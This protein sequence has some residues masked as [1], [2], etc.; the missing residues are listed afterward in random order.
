MKVKVLNLKTKHAIVM[1]VTSW[2]CEATVHLRDLSEQK[3]SKKR[4][5]VIEMSLVGGRTVSFGT[6]RCKLA[7]GQDLCVRAVSQDKCEMP[8]K[9]K[10]MMHD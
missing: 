4:E 6:K 9:T 5:Q 3:G 1:M 10:E 7:T 2:R 8:A